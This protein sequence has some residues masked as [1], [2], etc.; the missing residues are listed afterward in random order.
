MYAKLGRVITVILLPLIAIFF[1]VSRSRRSRIIVKNEKDEVLLVRSWLGS[2]EWNLPGGGI[3]FWENPRES[4]MRELEEETGITDVGLELLGEKQV[5]GMTGKYRAMVF[6]AT[7]ITKS[8]VATKK[9]NRAEIIDIRWFPADK[10]P[11][12]AAKVARPYL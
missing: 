11:K 6:Q 9:F 1:F 2:Q 4:A 8:E 3:K 10:L 5:R 7:A 12:H